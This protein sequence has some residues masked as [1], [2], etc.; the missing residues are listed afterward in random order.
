MPK[1][2]EGKVAIVTGSGQGIGKGIAVG[3]A[4]EGVKVVTN[5]LRPESKRGRKPNE[6]SEA[7]RQKY[8]EL[9]G[10][11]ESTAKLIIEE[12]GKALPIYTDVCD[13]EMVGEMVKQAIDTFG[14]LD[15]IV[16][17]AA[18]MY[19]GPLTATIEPAWEFVTQAKLKGTYNLMKHAVPYMVEQKFGRVINVASYAWTG[20]AGL[21]GYSAANAGVVGLSKSCAKEL[22]RTGVTV[23]V[24]CPEA[25]SPGHVLEFS[26]MKKKLSSMGIEIPVEKMKEI[27]DAHGPAENLG[28]FI[29]YLSTEEAAFITG[30]VFAVTGGGRINYF[31]EPVMVKEGI[32]KTDRLWTVGELIK[33]VP[34]TIL[35]GY[36]STATLDEHTTKLTN[37]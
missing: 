5:D 23:N 32:E 11:A 3:L 25:D 30:A 17:N 6:L 15:I 10:D 24:I 22:Y 19:A 29:A 33:Q 36:K 35:K 26:I 21:A 8:F 7:D 2:L 12:G 16:N 31:T 34:E 1:T 20:L 14:R 28:P 18:G 13:H 37:L 9:T 27:A 4:R